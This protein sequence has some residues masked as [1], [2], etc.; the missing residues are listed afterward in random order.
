MGKWS[1]R[2]KSGGSTDGKINKRMSEGSGEGT[3]RT[4]KEMNQ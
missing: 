1:D 4:S 2:D 3:Y